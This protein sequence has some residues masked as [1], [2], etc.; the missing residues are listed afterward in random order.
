[1]LRLLDR[2]GPAFRSREA[3]PASSESQGLLM[4][5]RPGYDSLAVAD[6]GGWWSTEGR[7]GFIGSGDP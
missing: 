4:S 1:M 5:R 3:V 7:P 2:D 6:Q